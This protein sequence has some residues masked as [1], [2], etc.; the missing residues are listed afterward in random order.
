VS[1]ERSSLIVES[2]FFGGSSSRCGCVMTLRKAL[3]DVVWMLIAR[4]VNAWDCGSYIPRPPFFKSLSHDNSKPM[5]M[6]V[7]I[8]FRRA[9]E[10][11]R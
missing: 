6:A 1:I 7:P 11:T 2:S 9:S 8:E 4:S 5:A 3:Q 10:I